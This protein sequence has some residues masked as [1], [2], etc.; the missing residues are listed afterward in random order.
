MI[1]F[2]LVIFLALLGF[3]A[4]YTFRWAQNGRRR[5]LNFD[6]PYFKGDGEPQ[7]G[8]WSPERV[9]R[10][11]EIRVYPSLKAYRDSQEM[12]S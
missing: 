6:A 2:D 8:T 3:A 5:H 11:D 4:G 12:A 9:T 7:P 10:M 1:P